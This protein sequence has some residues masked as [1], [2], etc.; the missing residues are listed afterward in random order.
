MLHRENRVRGYYTSS[1]ADLLKE[2]MSFYKI[3]QGALAKKLGVSQKDISDLLNHR[4]YLN[5]PLASRLENVTGVS[6][7]LLLALDAN[8]QLHKAK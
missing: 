4:R 8:Y 5:A 1:A 6:S 3:S 7:Q 2:V